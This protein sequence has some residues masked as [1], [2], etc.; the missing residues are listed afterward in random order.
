ML[1]CDALEKLELSAQSYHLAKKTRESYESLYANGS[2]AYKEISV[3]YASACAKIGKTRE[4]VA[5]LETILKTSEISAA[6]KMKVQIL[7]AFLKLSDKK[8]RNALELIEEGLALVESNSEEELVLL[9]NKMFAL[10][11]LGNQT[12]G[13]LAIDRIIGSGNHLP[14]D[15]RNCAVTWK[16][17]AQKSFKGQFQSLPD[18][19][20]NT[21]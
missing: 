2:S 4:A 12:E 14:V 9:A 11:E 10:Y 8:Y 13:K 15:T 6:L 1:L 17:L 3:T 20:L 19:V 18:A 5:I 21:N 7:F 16:W